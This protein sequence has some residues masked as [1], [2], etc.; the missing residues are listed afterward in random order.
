MK[1]IIAIIVATLLIIGTVKA[2]NAQTVWNGHFEGRGFDSTVGRIYDN[3]ND[4]LCYVYESGNA[5]NGGISCIK[6]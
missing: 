1:V 6:K 5:Q 3:E 4:V 2:F